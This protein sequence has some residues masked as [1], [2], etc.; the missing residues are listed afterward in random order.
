MSLL[1]PSDEVTLDPN[2]DYL[3]ELVGIGKKYA[4]PTALAKAYYHADKTIEIQNKRIDQFRSDYERER[5]QNLAR[6]QLEEVMDRYSK[7][8]LGE[9]TPQPEVQKPQYD[10]NQIESLVNSKIAENKSKEIEESNFNSVKSKMIERF[11]NRYQDAVVQ[12]INELGISGEEMDNMA[13][14]NPKVAMSVL[15]LFDLGPEQS[16]NS[17]FQPPMRSTSQLPFAPTSTKERTWTY[18]QD[19]KA[20]DPK[21][22]RSEKIQNQMTADYVR[23][24]PA[25]ED[26]DFRSLED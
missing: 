21:V 25:F 20:K 8:Q 10:M 4:D 17:L 23:L 2:A 14:K 6:E 16:K 15:G 22:Y 13:R 19:M 9:H 12:K 26:G 24:G 3:S 11:G 7:A 18:Y 1:T 5:A